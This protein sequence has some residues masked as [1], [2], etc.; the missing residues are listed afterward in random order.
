MRPLLDS[1]AIPKSA[2][3]VA[4]TSSKPNPGVS[5]S[6]TV[7]QS[8]PDLTNISNLAN[9]AFSTPFQTSN[10]SLQKGSMPSQACTYPGANNFFSPDFASAYA[11]NVNLFNSEFQAN[12]AMKT[13]GGG[14]SGYLSNFFPGMQNMPQLQL[15]QLGQFNSFNAGFNPR[16]QDGR[17]SLYSNPIP[18]VTAYMPP[19]NVS[20]EGGDEV[21][22]SVFASIASSMSQGP[23]TSFAKR[24]KLEDG[25]G[26]IAELLSRTTEEKSGGAFANVAGRSFRPI[27]GRATAMTFP[28]C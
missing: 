17:P 21:D 9:L 19:P 20:K 10:V 2:S 22:L 28:K 8:S 25:K 15:H 13:L 23:T 16:F 18:P 6:F 7:P 3:I 5:R 4:S 14:A 26:K 1:Q 24:Q 11:A 27:V 12:L